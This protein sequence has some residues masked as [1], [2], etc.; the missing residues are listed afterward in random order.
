ML[1]STPDGFNIGFKKTD[2]ANEYCPD[3]VYFECSCDTMYLTSFGSSY[4]RGLPFGYAAVGQNIRTNLRS[5][6]FDAGCLLKPL[7]E[8]N[9]GWEAV[10]PDT[11]KGGAVGSY[12]V[13]FAALEEII[14]VLNR[15]RRF[16]SD[17]KLSVIRF[18]KP[19]PGEEVTRLLQDTACL[20]REPI[21]TAATYGLSIHL[22]DG[23][24]FS[25]IRETPMIKTMV[26]NL[27]SPP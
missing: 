14:L 23:P 4:L 26:T 15:D 25:R 6:A 10:V 27:G 7:A 13:L 24:S 22:F 3:A 8:D 17:R 5:M 11:A 12:L 2:L 1:R 20:L 21:E 16:S 18:Q 9:G 19:Q